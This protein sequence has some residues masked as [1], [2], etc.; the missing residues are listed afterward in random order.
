MEFYFEKYNPTF[1][2]E[3]QVLEPE[4]HFLQVYEASIFNDVCK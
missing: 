1:A 4:G 2:Y 3:I